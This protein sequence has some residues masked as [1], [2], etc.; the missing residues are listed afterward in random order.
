MRKG[1]ELVS[2]TGTT[3]VDA[4][5]L[6]VVLD[7]VSLRKGAELVSEAGTTPVEAIS[8]ELD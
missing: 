2:G 1:A 7:V 5:S 6:A 3:P 4:A 8:L